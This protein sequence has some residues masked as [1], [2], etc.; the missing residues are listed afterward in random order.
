MVTIWDDYWLLRWVLATMLG[1]AVAG[2][3]TALFVWLAGGFGALLSG[4]L[5]GSILGIAQALILFTKDAQAIRKQWVI[6]SAI[7]GFFGIF[8][9]IALSV[10][11]IF[12]IWIGVFLIAGAFAGLLGLLQSLI[13]VK[14]LDGYAYL[15]IGMCIFAGGF[16]AMLSVPI[17][18]SRIPLLCSPTLAI[19]GVLTG[20]LLLGWMTPTKGEKKHDS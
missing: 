8:P 5:M 6:Y 10:V 18:Q 13:L 17:L 11:S 19:F 4:A 3:I 16:S 12:N 20:C 7:G 14:L 15:W 1:G 2:I 9:A